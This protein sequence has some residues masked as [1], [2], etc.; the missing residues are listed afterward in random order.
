MGVNIF[1]YVLE[2]LLSTCR[3]FQNEYMIEQKYNNLKDFVNLQSPLDIN[4]LTRIG[5]FD[6][7]YL[8]AQAKTAPDI[9]CHALN[10]AP[11][12]AAK[13]IV[14]N[15]LAAKDVANPEFCIPTSTARVMLFLR[16][17]PVNFPTKKPRT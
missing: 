7:E 16:S 11:G 14:A 12:T 9:L 13:G 10:N 15:W 2:Y 5:F 3:F 6:S 17:M 4:Y 1:V 8:A